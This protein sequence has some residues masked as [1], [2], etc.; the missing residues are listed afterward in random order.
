MRGVLFTDVPLRSAAMGRWQ[1]FVPGN[2][3]LAEDRI[4]TAAVFVEIFAMEL[5]HPAAV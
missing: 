1:Y 5:R 3:T 4:G 2:L